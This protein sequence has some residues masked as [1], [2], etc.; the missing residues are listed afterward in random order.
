VAGNVVTPSAPPVG[1]IDPVARAAPIA[2]AGY[3]DEIHARM[4]YVVPGGTAAIPQQQMDPPQVQNF[5]YKNSVT[6]VLIL[7]VVGMIFF[8]PLAIVAFIF[9]SQ[10]SRCMHELPPLR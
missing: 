3:Q 8:W 9:A 6:K 7:G 2:Y 10:V 1:L 5:A 4:P